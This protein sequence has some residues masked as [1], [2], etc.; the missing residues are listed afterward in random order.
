MKVFNMDAG[1]SDPLTVYAAVNTLRLDDMRAHLFRTHDGGRSWIEIN[2]GLEEGGP[3][4][5]I[6]EDPKRKGL[7]YA[8]TERRV[9]VSFDDGDHWQS[10]QLN[11][12]PSSVRDITI[13]DDD[14]IAATHGRGFWIL[15]DVTPLRQI[16]GGT[17]NADAVL[18][19][20]Q[21]AY[22]VRWNTNT[23]TPLPPEEPAGLN[24]PEGAIINYYLKNA[25]AGPVTLEVIDSQQRVVRRYSSGDPVVRPDP[26][27]GNLPLYWFRPPMVLSAAAGMHRFTWDVHYQPLPGGGGGRGAGG[28][29][30]AA[31]PYNT[32]PSPTAP[33]VRPGTYTVKLTVDGRSFTQPVVV[34]QDPRVR[35]PAV[36]M[37]R[38]Y[39]LTESAY[40]GALDAQK[41]A[42]DAQAVDQQMAADLTA[43]ASGLTGVMN[44]L[45]A[46]D[47]QP[48]ALQIKTITTALNNASAAL[49]RWRALRVRAA[50]RPPS[51]RGGRS[52][53]EGRGRQSRERTRTSGA[54]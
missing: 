8:A 16:D 21:T 24:P 17:A 39:S 9:Y 49:A 29:P 38:V 13:K 52:G 12:A 20:P 25:A 7:L 19:K 41:A 5:S 40:V 14:L 32:V 28:L 34:R 22:R 54:R 1:H 26:V 10:L 6:R 42:Q 44:S 27:R 45:Q 2:T 4:S 37:E 31:V 53:R 48:T 23:D 50:P 30:I 11:M 3:T 33:W 46:A 51:G 43:A 15:D 35:T 18:F 47:A 36:T